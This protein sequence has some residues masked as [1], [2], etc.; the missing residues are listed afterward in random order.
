VLVAFGLGFVGWFE[1]L[2]LV[3]PRTARRQKDRY[4]RRELKG[5]R[6]LLLISAGTTAWLLCR[7][8]GLQVISGV[9]DVD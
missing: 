7:E 6:H 4:Q 3:R 8:K 1:V 2:K 9:K 5:G